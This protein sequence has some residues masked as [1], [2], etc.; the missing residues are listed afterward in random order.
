MQKSLSKLDYF[1]LS[2]L[3][4]LFE[5]QS[6]TVAACQLETTQPKISRALHHLRDLFGD[7]LFVRHQHGLEPNAMAAKIY[8]IA[9]TIVE[10]YHQLQPH[11]QSNMQMKELNI[12]AQPHFCPLL[13]KAIKHTN[14]TCQK[15]YTI[16]FL[17]WTKDSQRQ[18]GTSL[19]DY[20]VT[21]NPAAEPNIQQYPLFQIKRFLFVARKNH[22]AL[23]QP[24]TL[25][26]VFD[27]PLALLNYPF[28]SNATH[29]LVTIAEHL[30]KDYSVSMKTHDLNLLL[31]HIASSNDVGLMAD[32]LVHPLIAANPE[33]TS[34]EINSLWRDANVPSGAR[35]EYHLILQA[36]DTCDS[37]YSQALAEHICTLIAQQEAAL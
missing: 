16:N 37:E 2:V 13:A 14:E 28:N 36:A 21:V 11:M 8:P 3:V 25:D 9:K 1:T 34:L 26:N 31:G 32:L 22:V 20:C 33:L 12:A 27:F 29:K 6:A 23:K 15:S 19:L 17:P 10:Q 30:K 4:E 18:I 24:L 5:K 35:P 7:E